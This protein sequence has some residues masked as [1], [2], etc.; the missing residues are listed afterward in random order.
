[1]NSQVLSDI[2][3]KFAV[4]FKGI[5]VVFAAG[6]IFFGVFKFVEQG[7][8]TADEV[9]SMKDTVTIGLQNVNSQ[10]NRI[11]IN[12]LSLQDKVE[13]QSRNINI[14]Q[15]SYIDYVR[16]NTKDTEELWNYLKDFM[17]TEKKNGNE[18]TVYVIRPV[19]T[20]HLNFR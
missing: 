1:M 20:L 10:L 4:V 13:N 18:P 6:A 14:L 8:R 11:N 2:W 19:S 17:D 9:K 3:S 16:K 7:N 12:V 15:K 5:G